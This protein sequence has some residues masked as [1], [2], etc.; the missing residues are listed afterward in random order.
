VAAVRSLVAGLD[1]GWCRELA[2]RAV[3]AGT[4]AE[5][6]ELLLAPRAAIE[7]AVEV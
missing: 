1:L 2:A 3:V 5:V 6:T 4:L 7:G